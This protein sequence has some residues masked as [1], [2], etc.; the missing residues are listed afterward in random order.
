MRKPKRIFG[1][2]WHVAH[3]YSLM[4]AFPDVEFYMYEG[5]KRRWAPE[6]RPEPANMTLVPWYEPGK[7]DLAIL[8]VDGECAD[9]LGNK[10]DL[11]KSLN[12]LIQDIP[13]VVINHGT[14]WLP[15]KFH[16]YVKQLDVD[17]QTNA[18][19][20]ICVKEMDKL[21]GD[22][23]DIT[24]SKQAAKDWG[25]GTPIIHGIANNPEEEYWDKEKEPIVAF[26][27]SPAGWDYYYNRANT[28]HVQANLQDH[29]IRSEYLR[30]NVS[31]RNFDEYRDYISRVLIGVFMTRESPMPRARTEMM[32]S[33]CCIISGKNHDMGDMFTGLEFK[34]T[35]NGDLIKDESGDIIPVSDPQKAEIVWGDIEKPK[36]FTEKI[37]WLYKNPDIA[38]IIGQN[39]KE[40]AKQV[41]DMKRYREDWERVIESL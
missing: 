5:I 26:N 39:G 34:K 10:G 30:V 3:N 2:V 22:L 6:S 35:T 15:E 21:L 24:N 33:G 4:T 13:K 16:K 38:K 31:V 23:V 1:T 28:H 25:R 27:V 8:H 41:F 17:Q 37:L 32:L 29:G 9:P 40:K 7:Y 20:D 11:F 36:D 19:K 12:E 14:P 18:A